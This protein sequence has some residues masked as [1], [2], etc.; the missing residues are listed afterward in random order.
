MI[1]FEKAM[2]IKSDTAMNEG[3]S[4]SIEI[5]IVRIVEQVLH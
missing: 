1:G 3:I 5:L 4:G 2:I